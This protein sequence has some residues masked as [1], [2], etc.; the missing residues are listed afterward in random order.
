MELTDIHLKES[1]WNLIKIKFHAYNVKFNFRLLNKA[2][3]SDKVHI[4]QEECN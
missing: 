4:K 3:L 1:L 2:K